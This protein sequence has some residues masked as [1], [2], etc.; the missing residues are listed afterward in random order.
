MVAFDAFWH[1]DM[2]KLHDVNGALLVLLPKSSDAFD[3]K[4]Y[5]PISLTHLMGKLIS[6]VL[7]NTVTGHLEELVHQSQSAFIKGR[8]IH[9][10]FRFIHASTK[11][12]HACQIPFLL[13]KVD[14][15]C[16]FD[17]VMWIFLVEIML[18]MGFS[19]R[20]GGLG[21]TTS[22]HGKHTGHAQWCSRPGLS[23][24]CS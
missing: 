2:R 7:S 17:S 20:M 9:D 19:K 11:M 4:D 18:H 23:V 16:A 13:L 22:L 10:N 12:L 21:L 8:N 14:I 3:I 24:S 1:S 6:K 15:A 5:W